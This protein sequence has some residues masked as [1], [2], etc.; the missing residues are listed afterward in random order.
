MIGLAIILGF[1]G[2]PDVPRL[3]RAIEAVENSSWTSTGGG[4]QWS[5][6]TWS[7]ETKEDFKKATDPKFS[8]ELAEQRLNKFIRRLHVLDIRPTPYLLA[9]M[10]NRGWSGALVRRKNSDRDDYAQRVENYFIA[11]ET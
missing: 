3:V 7:E 1:V 4:L 8:R 9:L 5:K 6:A 11:Y 2:N 10:W